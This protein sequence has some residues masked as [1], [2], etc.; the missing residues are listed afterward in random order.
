M[1]TKDQQALLSKLEN[2][3]NRDQLLWAAGYL[4]GRAGGAAAENTNAAAG[5]LAIFFATETGNSKLVAQQL[6]K[7][8]KETG[9]KAQAKPVTRVNIDELKALEGPAIFVV[10]TH[11]E[12]DPPETALH[13]YDALKAAPDGAL[14]KLQFI[15]LGLGDSSYV[16]FC[17][18][19]RKLD[20]E[21][22]RLGAKALHPR[23]EF[24]VDYASHIPGWIKQAVSALQSQA[25]APVAVT[26][27]DTP[28]I[29]TGRGY[30][31]LEPVTGT[32]T[33]IINLNDTG[34]NKETYHIEIEYSDTLSYQPGDAAG[35]LLPDAPDGYSPRLYSIAS[36][37]AAHGQSVHLTVALATHQS[38]DG[39]KG[40]GICS[41]YLAG[42]KVGDSIQFY[43]H[44][45]HQFRLAPD[46][47]DIIM[48]GPGTGIAP[49]RSFV[50][51]RADRGADGRNWLFFGDQHAHC[52][53]LYQLEWQDHVQAGNIARADF[54]FSRDQ[55][56]K[57][58]VQHRMKEHA[59]ELLEWIENGAY[60]YVCGSK[61]P[62]SYDVDATLVEILSSKKGVGAKDFLADL[63]DEGRYVKDVY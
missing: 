24:D 36:S 21:L 54:A 22:E 29:A 40:F 62:M 31:R 1:L 58:Y 55:K 27:D 39:T 11:G 13:F 16:E 42:L 17:G 9:W 28:M 3:L 6:L 44:Q 30:S 5:K 7:P 2:A 35:I 23:A 20:A 32:I 60:I 33:E 14:D 57:I 47:R 41:H 50:Y 51:E 38:P 19:A 48:I 18:F 52:D 37:P 8:A 61:D 56:E 25:K 49:F 45:N 43:I 63:A 12:G 26:I 53:F 15:M 46:D 34:S 59:D 4:A 10:A